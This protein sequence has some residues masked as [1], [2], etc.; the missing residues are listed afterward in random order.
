MT[1]QP[2]TGIPHK[3]AC[4]EA[5]HID[6][7]S[8]PGPWAPWKKIGVTPGRGFLLEVFGKPLST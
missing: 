3:K 5:G 4:G 8:V 1:V 7:Y 2:E 6:R